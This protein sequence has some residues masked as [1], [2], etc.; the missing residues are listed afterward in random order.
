MTDFYWIAKDFS[1]AEQQLL[2]TVA[3]YY[4]GRLSQ[5]GKKR[6]VLKRI[7]EPF[8][9]TAFTQKRALIEAGTP[10]A[11]ARGLGSVLAGAKTGETVSFDSLGIMI[12]C[13]RNKVFTIDYLKRFLLR[14]ALM[15]GNLAMLYTEDTYR[16]P[17]EPFFGYMRGGYTLEEIQEL[18]RFAKRIGVELVGCIQTL[19]HMHQLLRHRCYEKVCDTSGVLMTDAPETYELI[20]K[21]LSFWSKALT[22]RRIHLG[23]DEAHDLG[24]GN[25]LDR[26]GY[27]KSSDI[28][29]RH[30]D[31]V[32]GLCCRQGLKPIICSDMFF[33][34]A[35][36]GLKYYEDNLGS[37][38][39]VQ[40]ELPPGLQLCYWDYYH[41]TAE[42]YK[43]SIQRH[44]SF[45]SEPVVASGI[46]TWG[47]FWCS[48]SNVREMAVP[49]ISACRQ[50]GIRELFFTMWGDNGGFCLYDSALAG[51]ELCCGVAYGE[52]ADQ[53]AFYSRRFQAICGENYR[54]YEAAATLQYCSSS[55]ILWDDPLQGSA[56]LECEY[57]ETLSEYRQKLTKL[58]TNLDNRPV[59]SGKL[60]AVRV[61]AA[62]LLSKIRLRQELLAAY[63]RRDRGTLRNLAEEAIPGILCRIGEFDELFR[64]DWLETAKPF[65]LEV[66][67]RR[68]AGLAARYRELRRL[69]LEFLGGTLPRIAELDASQEAASAV[70]ETGFTPDNI[71]SGS[72]WI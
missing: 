7:K 26:H 51:L 43:N 25:F 19:G 16:L 58:Q 31:K 68:N 36:P 22:S 21:M 55:N 70:R 44:R 8:L 39:P 50:T 53:E 49:C 1:P 57:R 28:F 46:W 6:L 69:L 72:C 9:R 60:Q 23:M 54:L 20:D 59:L 66:I 15:G 14:L 38:D 12:D 62:L 56:L 4:P 63:S 41:R 48:L 18:D 65:G 37:A 71:Y 2:A 13:S 42:H 47:N 24:R 11:F 33:S 30:L 52:Q 5:T 40:V 27:E 3:E 35:N 34:L 17:G 29:L 61:L 45:G 67:Q 32:N 64:A 10:A